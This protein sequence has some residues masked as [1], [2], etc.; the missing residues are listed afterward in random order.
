MVLEGCWRVHYGVDMLLFDPA[1][2]EVKIM[3][4][5][6]ELVGVGVAGGI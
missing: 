2:A 5:V 4:K 6:K 1:I 3:L